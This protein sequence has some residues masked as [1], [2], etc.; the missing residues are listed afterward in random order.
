[1]FDKKKLEAFLDAL[2]VDTHLPSVVPERPR[3]ALDV[4]MDK[5]DMII[6]GD[7]QN[8]GTAEFPV[9]GKAV[10]SAL[11]A[12]NTLWASYSAP[13]WPSPPGV[14]SWCNVPSFPEEFPSSIE[15]PQTKLNKKIRQ[16]KSINPVKIANPAP[17]PPEA[18]P[19]YTHT[20]T[21]WRGWAV[22]N[23]RLSSLG[24]D[25]EWMPKRAYRAVCHA[26]IFGPRHPAPHKKCNCGYW[27]FKSLDV[28]QDMLRDYSLHVD[29]IGQVEIWGRV[30]ECEHG[31]R[32]EFAYPKELWLLKDGYE[33]LSW[34]YG[35]P[36]RRLS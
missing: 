36:V 27:S 9:W 15:T 20:I 1:M 24:T 18:M 14:L 33:S 19:D 11:S 16:L 21:A 6:Q 32:S 3:S 12:M 30:V 23:G 31:F 17:V 28:M 22:V 29:V 10:P 4:K 34:D 5:Y 2:R 25:S 13:M 7:Y 35:V 8:F 26:K